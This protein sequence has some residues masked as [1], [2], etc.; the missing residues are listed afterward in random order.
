MYDSIFI[1]KDKD[2]NA[3]ISKYSSFMQ[4]ENKY[5]NYRKIAKFMT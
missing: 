1:Y 3:L 5:S 2:T 4:I